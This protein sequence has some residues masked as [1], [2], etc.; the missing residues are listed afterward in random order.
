MKTDAVLS[1]PLTRIP[2]ANYRCMQQWDALHAMIV[3]ETIELQ[4][5]LCDASERWK[6]RPR[7][8]GLRLSFIRKVSDR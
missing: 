6:P 3:Y 7:A 4:T 5:T 1:R 2:K 8:S